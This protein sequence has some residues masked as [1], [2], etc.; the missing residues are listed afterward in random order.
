MVFMQPGLVKPYFQF[1]LIC[2]FIY[3][4]HPFTT[5]FH[6]VL[7]R[8]AMFALAIIAALIRFFPFVSSCLIFL[9]KRATDG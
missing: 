8:A 2:F 3:F 5:P 1:H 4:P 7:E 9:F 6:F